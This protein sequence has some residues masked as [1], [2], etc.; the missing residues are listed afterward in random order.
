MF[1]PQ[2]NT[3]QHPSFRAGILRPLL[4]SAVVFL[5]GCN[6]GG[7]GPGS[8]SGSNPPPSGLTYP[9]HQE[10]QLVNR[11]MAPSVPTLTGT[12]D[13]WTVSPALPQGLSL[14]ALDGTI[15]GTPTIEAP[16][17]PFVVTAS[18]PKGSTQVTIKFRVYDAPRFLYSTGP[19]DTD[20]SMYA[21]GA[22]EDDMGFGPVQG[23]GSLTP[24]PE[25]IVFH[26]GGAL[27]FVPNRGLPGMPG[28]VSSYSVDQPTGVM[29]HLGDVPSG[30]GPRRL[31][32]GPNGNTA[33]VVTHEDNRLYSYSVDSV[34]GELA[35]L[36]DVTTNTGPTRI[37]VDPLGRF[38]YVLHDQ[39]ADITVHPIDPITGA[40]GPISQA[41]NYWF[42]APS[43]IAINSTGSVVYISFADQDILHAYRVSASDG[44]LTAFSVVPL[45]Q[46]P[47]SLAI[48]PYD[49]YL[50]VTCED[51]DLLEILELDKPTGLVVQAS[52]V[53]TASAPSQVTLDET[54]L[55]A[56]VLHTGANTIRTY[57]IDIVSSVITEGGSIRTRP[58]ATDISVYHGN[59]PVSPGTDFV[60]ALGGGSEDISGFVLNEI[61]GQL[62]PMPPTSMAGTGPVDLAVDPLG[63][64]VFVAHGASKE[65]SVLAI[66]NGTGV[67]SETL[68]RTPLSEPPSAIA[69]D[70]GGRFLF[71]TATQSAQ[72]IAYSIHASTGQLSM[73]SAAT[74]GPGPSSVQVDPTGHFV[75]VA[76]TGGAGDTLGAYRFEDGQFASGPQFELAPGSPGSMRF[77]PTGERLYVALTGSNLVVPYSIDPLSGGLTL[78]AADS[79]PAS[80]SPELFE[81][82]RSGDY[83]FSVS[84]LANGGIGEI[85]RFRIEQATGALVYEQST[86]SGINPVSLRADHAGAFLFVIND[87]SNDLEVFG[88]DR[89][90][91]DLTT[92]GSYMVGLNPTTLDV[93]RH[94]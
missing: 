90:T 81:P 39:S 35:Y 66:A 5:A 48:S 54:G 25:Q 57:N 68:P 55:F 23:T 52:S 94:W 31:V 93:T 2:N 69:V 6:S 38:I 7:K 78:E 1:A 34:T 88:V 30:E 82:H 11:P 8:G 67:L 75:Y 13:T 70:P 63:R 58:Q 21:I 92:L 12:V 24:G 15:Q 74:T 32:L 85:M 77:S 49:D 3:D 62:S 46:G 80:G 83:G 26:P 84:P 18:G 43:A 36:D 40:A 45:P 27:A 42:A 9:N 28:S 41:I 33:Y 76:N 64:F 51:D 61:S 91:G 65:L 87:L 56:F 19:Q 60:Y 22:F 47:N 50:Y 10:R 89:A 79:A 37:A 16:E 44:S 72:V 71:V 20:M 59:G 29:R 73:S 14:D 17:A 86:A 4:L 53:P